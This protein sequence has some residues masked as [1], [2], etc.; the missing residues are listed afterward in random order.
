MSSGDRVF[1]WGFTRRGTRPLLPALK[2]PART[3]TFS[4]ISSDGGWAIFVLGSSFFRTVSGYLGGHIPLYFGAG[5]SRFLFIPKAQRSSASKGSIRHTGRPLVPKWL[6]HPHRYNRR[7]HK[8][9]CQ[10]KGRPWPYSLQ[11]NRSRATITPMPSGR[12]EVPAQA[13]QES[14]PRSRSSRRGGGVVIVP[15]D[16]LQKVFFRSSFKTYVSAP[17]RG[18]LH[19]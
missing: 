14:R 6:S 19:T 12:L 13:R 11:F 2:G 8:G 9:P 15:T 5:A 17:G 10:H 1:F 7:R 4:Q 16:V 18:S 3:M